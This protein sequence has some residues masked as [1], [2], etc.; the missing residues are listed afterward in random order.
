M[1]ASYD[2]GINLNDN[3]P[4]VV[5]KM[6]S[7][8]KQAGVQSVRIWNTVANFNNHTM[9]AA[10]SRAI[11]YANKGFDVTLEINTKNGVVPSASAVKGWFA[12]A[13]SNSALKNAVDRWEIGN[14]PDHNEYWQGSLSQY[15]STYL[16][17]AYEALH[18]AGEQVVSAGPSW[19]PQ[20]VQTMIN[21]GMLNYT[22]YVGFHP[23]A[24]GVSGVLNDMKQVNAVVAGRKPIA[25]TEWNVRGL[26]NNK[27]AWAQAVQDV[28][29]YVPQYSALNYYF[30]AKYQNSP[31]GPGGILNT[32][33]DPAS[34]F[35][36]A[37]INGVA[38][39]GGS[40]S[41]ST[42]SSNGGSSNS[43]ST[44]A[45]N[46]ASIAGV[47]FGDSNADGVY[48]SGDKVGGGR[49]VFIDSNGNGK[50][51][52][53]E[54][55]T[56]SDSKGNYKF[57]G[58]SAGTYKISRVFPSGYKLS[59]NSS[60]YVTATVATGQQKS[61][62]NI[63]SVTSKTSI[64]TGST[65]NSAAGVGAS[66]GGV[67][68]G[69]SNADG[70]YN[71]GDSIGA[72]RTVFIDSNGNGRLDSGET[73]TTT[74]SKGN[75]KF[76]GLSAGTYKI[77]RVFPS[78]YKLSNNNSGYVTATVAASQQKSGVD[79]GSVTSKT[80]ISNNSSS[81]SSSSSTPVVTAFQII[82]TKTGK[83][84]GSY[85]NIT[86]NLTIKLSSMANRNIAVVAL[87]NGSTSSL[88]L[89]AL[90]KTTTQS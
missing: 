24:K 70:I 14:E 17:P 72:G 25:F 34:Y 7:Q 58:L 57:T 88:K 50:L 3:S 82:D 23:Y 36:N 67:V 39:I 15:V 9:T 54:K 18:A 31:A 13:T 80:V 46:G 48:N 86:S 19:N 49:T 4:S 52:K 90:G 51:D 85:S 30:A 16:K 77:S 44:P 6:S 35:Y 66:I 21:A 42:G 55:T 68:F 63:G 1:S 74:D 5:S 40:S 32:S 43:G 65:G 53:G 10:M 64:S 89:T 27:A 37:F 12:W 83:V 45:G 33:L 47:I 69:D 29:K 71:S 79:I 84:L 75:Y 11:D 26:E 2:V 87:A 81:N 76:T 62:V 73:R 20:D 78:G 61:G 60:G 38:S 22:D 8:L 56:T 41:P 28:F 59:N